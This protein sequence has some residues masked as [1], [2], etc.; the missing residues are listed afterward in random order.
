MD[1]FLEF[2]VADEIEVVLAPLR[3]P[4]GMIESG[5]L[6]FGVV[7]SEVNDELIGAG[8]K[9]LQHF[10][11][12]VEP[13]GLRNARA[14]FDNGV[15]DDGVGIELDSVEVGV[16]RKK[17]G[18][19][20]GTR[21]VEIDLEEIGGAHDGAHVGVKMRNVDAGGSG[22]V[23]LGMNFGFD[24]GSFGVSN[25]VRCEER[26]I[27]IGVEKAGVFGLRGNGRPTVAGPI[28]VESKVDA[29]VG[30]GMGLGPL[31]D[32][33]EPGTRNHDAGGSDPVIFESFLDGGVDGVHHAVVV[34]VNDEK[35]RVERIAEAMGERV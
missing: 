16:A 4:V 5:T 25:D 34:G 2:G 18:K 11:V 17:D 19:L 32:F 6:D 10:L 26:Q 14:N 27:A 31:S 13:L 20:V 29:E 30:V 3:A 33:G 28:G 21:S 24:V 22:F 35:A 8:R 9:S 23:D 12:G 7:V 15:E 1:E